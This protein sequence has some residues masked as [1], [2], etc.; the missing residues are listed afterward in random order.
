MNTLFGGLGP[1]VSKEVMKKFD[2]QQKIKKIIYI[3]VAVILII[4][5]LYFFRKGNKRYILLDSPFHLETDFVKSIPPENE[6]FS[7]A[8]YLNVE[9]TPTQK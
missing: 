8:S 7:E 9:S 1:S 2:T 4:V 5:F 6:T 3:V